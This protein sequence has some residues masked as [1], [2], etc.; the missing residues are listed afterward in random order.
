MLPRV[1]LRDS[2]A[3]VQRTETFEVGYQFVQGSRAY[4]AAV[5]SE[6]VSNGAFTMAADADFLP[7]SDS[8][9][10]LVSRSQIFNAG[11]FQRVGYSA[12]VT[13][14]VGERVELT[15]AGGRAGALLAD[16]RGAGWW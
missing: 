8:L 3:R 15:V 16:A 10:D 5:Y 1:S 2:Q 14:A 13:Q 4:S 7:V 6:N 12:S 9:P 11:N